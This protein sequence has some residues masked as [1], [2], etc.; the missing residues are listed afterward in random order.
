MRRRRSEANEMLPPGTE[1]QSNAAYGWVDHDA[2]DHICHGAAGKVQEKFA[3]S[4]ALLSQAGESNKQTLL[5]FTDH[6]FEWCGT[7]EAE[8]S[9]LLARQCKGY[10]GLLREMIDRDMLEGAN[11]FFVASRGSQSEQDKGCGFIV[12]TIN[13]AVR[14]GLFEG[15][16]MVPVAGGVFFPA[17]ED[18]GV[19]LAAASTD[20]VHSILGEVDAYTVSMAEASETNFLKALVGQSGFALVGVMLTVSTPVLHF[21]VEMCDDYEVRE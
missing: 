20:R 21:L 14:Q 18:G 16:A 19:V 2:D 4:V 11:N 6:V 8:L 1:D 13:A 5:E 15:L 9:T 17:G 12:N 3:S 7:E 10:A